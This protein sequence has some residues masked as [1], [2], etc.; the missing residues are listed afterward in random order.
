LYNY[1][2]YS[3]YIKST[4]IAKNIMW[5]ADKTK[6]KLVITI[7]LSK[8]EKSNKDTAKL[9]SNTTATYPKCA[10][11]PENIGYCGRGV[12]RQT[13]R[14]IPIILGREKWVWQFSPYAYFY[15]HGIAINCKHTPMKVDGNTIVKLLDFVEYAPQYF[16]GCN[17]A[18]PIVGGS[19]LTHDHFQGGAQLLPMHSASVLKWYTCIESKVNIGILDW[20]NSVIY[21]ES[22]D[23]KAVQTLA[24]TIIDSWK[25]Y[26]DESVGILAK[27][28]D[29][30]NTLTPIVRKVDG[31]YRV[32]LIL[33]NNRCDEAHPDGIFHA[34]KEYHNIKSEAIGLIEAMGMFILPAR[35][36][37]QLTEVSSAL[38]GKVNVDNLSEDMEIHRDMIMRLVN[39]YGVDNDE[40]K[41]KLI[42]KE[43]VERVCENILDN[44]SVFKKNIQGA[45]AFNKFILSCNITK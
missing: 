24:T 19:I 28:T 17:A 18:L 41:A 10:I 5:S 43:E 12:V 21:L 29:V 14:A 32:Y 2:V 3:D 30:H 8:P 6:G 23:R 11:C 35:L 26:S 9:L 44:T 22:A 36:S 39:Q 7:N 16:I 27:T 13:L 37:R 4:A 1:G 42:V 20:Y 25:N 45:D 15:Q 33:R 34:H 40:D 38:C 31:V